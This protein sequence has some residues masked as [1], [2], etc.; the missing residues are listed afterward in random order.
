M[1]LQDLLQYI[2]HFGYL[3]LFFCLWLGIIGMPIPDEMIVM[4]GGFVS[5][6]GI[7]NPVIAFLLTYLGVVSGLSLGY[8]LGRT[9]G[10]RI[11]D[12]IKKKSKV[13]YIDKS[14][15]MIEKYREY[16][17]V[18]SYFIPV[19]RHIVPYIVGINK[20]SFRSYAIYSYSTGFVWTVLYFTLGSLFGENIEAIVELSTKYGLIV[21]LI[22]FVIIFVHTFRNNKRRI[23]R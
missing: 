8:F 14:H 21:G 11:L 4:S 5:S 9:V 3:A 19:V 15:Q 23:N 1:D 10:V 18:I 20:M 12:T 13:M 2:N 17:L 22:I 16:A 6:I 7:L